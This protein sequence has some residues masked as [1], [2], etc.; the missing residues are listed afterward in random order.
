MSRPHICETSRRKPR[1]PAFYVQETSDEKGD[2]MQTSRRG[3]ILSTL[4]MGSV[5]AGLPAAADDGHA[6]A[7]RTVETLLHNAHLALK[8]SDSNHALRSAIDA[9]FDFDV[10]ERFL[11]DKRASAYAPDDLERLRAL[12]P[13]FLAHLYREQFDKGL[14]QPPE[15]GGARS[16]RRDVIVS[17]SFQRSK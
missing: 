3:F 4:A 2:S 1:L 10:W 11:T 7:L 17:S 12:L 13:G 9:A 14:D 16:V 6:Q 5:L 15:L 8:Q